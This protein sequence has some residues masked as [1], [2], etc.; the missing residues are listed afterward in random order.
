MTKNE[1]IQQ[2]LKAL[3]ELLLD[4]CI[5]DSNLRILIETLESVASAKPKW[6]KEKKWQRKGGNVKYIDGT[7]VG[8]L[9]PIGNT[10]N[11][12][13]WG[14]YEV[15]PTSRKQRLENL[16]QYQDR[17]GKVQCRLKRKFDPHDKWATGR[18]TFD[19]DRVIYRKVDKF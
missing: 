4:G 10:W 17:G 13:G 3:R 16:S 11:F 2:A 14:T 15:V 6:S 12:T 9:R 8:D 18:C 5:P 7:P 1:A 19:E